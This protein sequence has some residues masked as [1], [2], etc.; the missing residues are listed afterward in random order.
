[1]GVKAPL[2]GSSHGPAGPPMVM[3]MGAS[4]DYHFDSEDGRGRDRS[5][6]VE[7]AGEFDPE[8]AF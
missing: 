2:P 3:K 4:R 8:C 6:A 1:M 7:A 5:G